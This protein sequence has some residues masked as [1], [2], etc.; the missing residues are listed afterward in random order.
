M[1]VDHRMSMYLSQRLRYVLLY[2]PSSIDSQKFVVVAPLKTRAA[3]DCLAL[4]SSI[5]QYGSRLFD[6]LFI[7]SFA[8]SISPLE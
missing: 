3:R 6:P 5:L 1:E 4:E 2:S 7:L 8:S